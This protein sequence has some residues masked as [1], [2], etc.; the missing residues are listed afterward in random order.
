MATTDEGDVLTRLHKAVQL[1]KAAKAARE[2]AASWSRLD[3]ADLDGSTPRWLNTNTATVSRYHRES[4]TA[5]AEY[6][7][8]YR[9]AELGTTEGPLA[10]PRF[11]TAT[12]RSALVLAG[13]VRVKLLIGG[14]MAPE[15]AHEKAL[16]KY[17]GIVRRQVLM[18][19]RQVIDRTTAQDERAVGWRRVTDG[20]P[21]AFC[22]M[23]CSRGPVYGNPEYAGVGAGQGMKFHGHCGCT[24]E[25]VYGEWTPSPREQVYIDEY[26]RAAAAAKAAGE[27]VTAKSVLP[28]MRES[29]AFSDSRA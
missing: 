16:A 10:K 11:D 23:L 12:S 7:T 1:S 25:I 3:V 27:K 6:V 17:L 2:A 9:E 15:T 29:A 14:G 19:G 28:R 5:A 21:C 13:P 18:G 20:K 26:D 8:D 22:G 24:A 4:V